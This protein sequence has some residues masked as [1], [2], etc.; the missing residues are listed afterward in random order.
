MGCVSAKSESANKN[1]G[2]KGTD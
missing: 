2:N 1:I